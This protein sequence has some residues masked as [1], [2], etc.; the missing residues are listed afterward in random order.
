M[1]RTLVALAVTVLAFASVVPTARAEEFFVAPPAGSQTE[2]F[3]FSGRG[4]R[5]GAPLEETYTAPNGTEFTA[6][7]SGQP[8]VVI[9]EPDGTFAIP[10]VPAVDFTGAP[11]GVW[12]AEFCYSDGNCWTV[13]FTVIP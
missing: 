9:V 5:P 11:F 4:F 6:F 7:V 13:N 2:P 12:E 3:L 8:A 10:V 1:R